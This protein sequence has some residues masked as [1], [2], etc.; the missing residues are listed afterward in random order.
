MGQGLSATQALARPAINDIES[1]R[2]HAALELVGN[3]MADALLHS[4]VCMHTIHRL[5][6]QTALPPVGG[7]R[8]PQ[9]SNVRAYGGY[10]QEYETAK[11]NFSTA[12]QAEYAGYFTRWGCRGIK[13]LV[14][15]VVNIVFL[16]LHGVMN[17]IAMKMLVKKFCKRKLKKFTN[18]KFGRYC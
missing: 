1:R 11:N 12:T 6:S 8:T 14:K 2:V 4:A 5:Y 10:V 18:I 16:V 15:C 9:Q 13:S 7:F 17:G 3:D